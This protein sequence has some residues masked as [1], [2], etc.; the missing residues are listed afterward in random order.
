MA[1]P[2]PTVT[3]RASLERSYSNNLFD[4]CYL[5]PCDGCI[6][7]NTKK[8]HAILW[9]IVPFSI[10]FFLTK[11]ALNRLV[12]MLERWFLYHANQKNKF[13]WKSE[14][15]FDRIPFQINIVLSFYD[16]RCIST[17]NAP[18]K[19]RYECQ[20]IEYWWWHVTKSYRLVLS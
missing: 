20:L 7:A 3:H 11:F 2:L 16:S 13:S 9:I 12:S 10:S 17:R 15:Q 4:T 1:K 18:V 19:Q 6:F 5:V 14:I 8:S